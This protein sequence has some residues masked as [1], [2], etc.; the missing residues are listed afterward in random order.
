MATLAPRKYPPF[1]RLSLFLSLLS[2]R[3]GRLSPSFHLHPL[4]LPSNGVHRSLSQPLA[5]IARNHTRGYYENDSGRC[6]FLFFPLFSSSFLSTRSPRPPFLF[7]PLC[8]DTLSDLEM[9]P[10]RDREKICI[11]LIEMK[12]STDCFHFFPRLLKKGR[13]EIFYFLKL[14]RG[15]AQLFHNRIFPF[16]LATFDLK[17]FPAWEKKKWKSI[18]YFRHFRLKINFSALKKR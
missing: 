4:P 3:T 7:L 17:I 5:V 10:S 16:C 14:L 2:R 15:E 8:Y 9:F 11:H 6:A 13:I 18:W 1:D 12:D